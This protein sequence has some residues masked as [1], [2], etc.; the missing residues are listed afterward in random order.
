MLRFQEF[1]GKAFLILHVQA[2]NL[3]YALPTLFL[4]HRRFPITWRQRIKIQVRAATLSV[5]KCPKFG[6]CGRILFNWVIFTETQSVRMVW[7]LVVNC[8]VLYCL[9]LF[10][11]ITHLPIRLYFLMIVEFRA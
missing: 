4:G 10:L 7:F 3:V 5:I 9:K 11:L 2:Q 1:L 6:L 8:V